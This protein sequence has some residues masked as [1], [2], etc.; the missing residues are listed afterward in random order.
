MGR[1]SSSTRG[2]RSDQGGFTLIEI[3]VVLAIIGMMGVVTVFNIDGLTPGERLR[4]AARKLA[5]MSDFIRSQATSSK[6]PAYLEIDLD[7]SRYRFVQ[8]PPK[9]PQG[10]P[11]DIETEYPLTEEQLAE[12]WDAFDWEP[13]PR[14]V[15]FHTVSFNA[16]EAGTYDKGLLPPIEYRSDGTCWTFMIQL[17][18]GD[19]QSVD[20]SEILKMSVMVNGLT[21]KSEV[22][23]DWATLPE[24][25]EYDFSLVMGSEAP[26]GATESQGAEGR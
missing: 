25:A 10:T 7:N 17:K 19:L 24:A 23:A 12:W 22:K 15:Y 11:I 26:G 13:L 4:S 16:S 3:L 2:D 18:A 5:G 1:F 14:D 8:D 6:I 9:D 20:K 21:G